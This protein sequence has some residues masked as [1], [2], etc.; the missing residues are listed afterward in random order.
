MGL[1]IKL[2]IFA[3][4]H[5]FNTLNRVSYYL[6]IELHFGQIVYMYNDCHERDSLRG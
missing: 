1:K 6:G 4:V 2:I 3:L 5:L